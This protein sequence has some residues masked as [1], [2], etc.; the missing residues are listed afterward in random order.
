MERS[1]T[2]YEVSLETVQ[3]MLDHASPEMTLRYATIKDQTLRREWER[4]QHRV[5]VRGE[6]IPLEPAGS[7]MSDAAWALE[8]LA[9][10]ADAPERVLRAAVAADLP[11]PQ[12]VPDLRQLPDHRRV[13]APASRPA[14]PHR[15]ADRPPLGMT[16]R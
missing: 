8:N 3:R 4:F 11:A 6:L 13:L 10:E 1:G 9:R 14:H 15:T 7:A 12:R 5:N 2:R 16:A